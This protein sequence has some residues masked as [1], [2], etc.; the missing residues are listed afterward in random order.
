MKCQQS[1]L[2]GLSHSCPKRK[3]AQVCNS[4]KVEMRGEFSQTFLACLWFMG[5]TPLIC[6]SLLTKLLH[7]SNFWAKTSGS[8]CFPMPKLS[9]LQLPPPILL[10]RC[11]WCLE[12]VEVLPQNQRHQLKIAQQSRCSKLELKWENRMTDAA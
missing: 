8:F 7:K 3:R 6:Q 4:H 11:G 2:V 5:A 12:M 10:P 9:P 1:I